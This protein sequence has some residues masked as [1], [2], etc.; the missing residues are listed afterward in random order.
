MTAFAPSAVPL[1]VFTDLDG[2][3]LDHTDYTWTPARPA[4]ARL[5]ALGAVVVLASSKTAP[6]VTPLQREMG[7][8]ECPA[9]VE[10]GAGLIGMAGPVPPAQYG[11]LRRALDTVPAELR[12]LFT[13]FGDMTDADVVAATGLGATQA[14]A[15]RTR[16]FSE[17]GLWHGTSEQQAAFTAHLQA[18][19]VQARRGGRFLTLSFGKTK[20][21]RMAQVIAALEPAHTL[22]LGDAP[23]DTE[24]LETADHG[25]IIA[26]PHHAALPALRTE[27]Q[28]RIT[29]TRDA[30]PAGWNDAVL[31]HLEFL[32]LSVET[33]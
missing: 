14:Q 6:E 27:E 24:M 18:A 13:G 12:A 2:T 4:L 17:P 25:I 21:D 9:I 16:A 28:G 10:N 7:L 3:L 31:A 11:D 15:A 33:G 29:R 19:G 20:A 32:N 5:A 26:N 23:N 8:A 30:G 22:A 1:V